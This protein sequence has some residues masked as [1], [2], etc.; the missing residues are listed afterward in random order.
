MA[1]IEEKLFRPQ[2]QTHAPTNPHD[3]PPAAP[4]V[5]DLGRIGRTPKDEPSPP[6]PTPDPDS[7]ADE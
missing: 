5:E 4:G 3:L 2:G 6:T 1:A 7:G